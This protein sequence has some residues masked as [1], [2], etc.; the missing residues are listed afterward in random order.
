MSSD[1]IFEGIFPALVTPFTA[2]GESVDD[3]VLTQVVEF[4][5]D[6]GVGGVIPCGSTGEFMNM[7]TDE[8][9]DVTEV[10]SSVVDGRVPVVPHTGALTTK[11]TIDLSRHAER[12]GAAAVMVI[13]PY[14]EPVTW[15]EV[16]AHFRALSDAINIPIMY[17]HMPAATG[18]PLTREQFE[19][20]AAIENIK[21]TKDSSANAVQLGELFQEMPDKLKVFNGEDKLTFFGLT[22][23]ARASVWGAANFFPGLAVELYDAIIKKQ[24]LPAAQEVW[25]RIWP[26]M[27]TVGELGYQS[28][29]KAGCEVVG[30]PVGNPR[31]PLLPAPADFKARLAD[32]L[33]ASG[34]AVKG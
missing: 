21:F 15:P 29:V 5:L 28:A 34:V 6:A 16:L 10:V 20:L 32:V 18:L 33:R 30:L 8:R 23:G 26:I 19:E 13:P 25:K 12:N 31:L 9:K 11:E 1:P 2:D 4:Q 22:S 24:D 7:T 3:A 27:T 17:Y 14:Y